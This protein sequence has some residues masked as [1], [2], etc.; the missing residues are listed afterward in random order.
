MKRRNANNNAVHS[1]VVKK[2]AIGERRP[3]R[4]EYITDD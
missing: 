1:K 2:S 3:V 4:Q